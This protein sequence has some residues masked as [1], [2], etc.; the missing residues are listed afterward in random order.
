MARIIF[1]EESYKIIGACMVV[2]K[3]LGHGF[4]PC[5]IRINDLSESVI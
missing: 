5:V 1:K 2:H 4:L 3:N